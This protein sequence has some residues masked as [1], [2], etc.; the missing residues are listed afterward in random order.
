MIMQQMMPCIAGT[1]CNE[2]VLKKK[3]DS[4]KRIARQNIQNS[5]VTHGFTQGETKRT[6]KQ[7]TK[8]D[9]Y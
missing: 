3:I 6:E 8:K 4:L 2:S 5:I 7:K 1:L 9:R